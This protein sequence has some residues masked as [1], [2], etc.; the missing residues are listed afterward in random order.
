MKSRP[1]SASTAATF[2][3]SFQP[4][5]KDYHMNPKISIYRTNGT[6][7]DTYINY[8]NGGFRNMCPNNF[9][10]NYSQLID[11]TKASN[12][13]PKFPIYK[14]NGLGRD[15]YIYSSSGGFYKAENYPGFVNSLR[16][17]MNFPTLK[18]Y[19]YVYYANHFAHPHVVNKRNKLYRY[20][21]ATSARLAKPKY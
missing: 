3:S 19:D 16:S 1:L 20:Q 4:K 15:S 5:L 8:D 14:P 10:I 7:R 12:I 2:G 21:R 6:G 17:P 9:R 11:N 18:K 13:N